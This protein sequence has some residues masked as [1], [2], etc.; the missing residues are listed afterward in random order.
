M[1]RRT[2][3]P[4]HGFTLIELAVAMFIGV[5]LLGSLLV[6]LSKQIETRK[7]ADTQRTIDQAI[8]ALLG[9]AATNGRLP[10][11]ASATSNGFESPVGGGTCTNPF[12][13]FLPAATLGLGPTD[14][15]GYLLDSW[16]GTQNRIRYAV[17][18]TTGTGAG[19]CP[20][21][22]FV[23]T[24][25]GAMRNCWTL[26]SGGSLAPNLL[27]CSTATGT[28]ASA[29]GS[30]LVTLTNTAPAIVYSLGNNMAT[31]APTAG[32][33]LDEAQ[34]PNP[35]SANNDR[36]FV[37]HNPTGTSA[38]NGEFDDLMQWLSPSL[39]NSKMLTAGQLP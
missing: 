26:I 8:E 37:W 12:N 34:N 11:P 38:V 4:A 25:S 24:T 35:N 23:Y 28:T 13:G 33:S 19:T 20:A 1:V 39:L 6:P 5:L 10:C 16:G 21:G 14:N 30:S 2:G 36:V 18:T 32:I 17:A 9:F 31:A 3:G 27:V 7:V 29:C 22:T 15:Q